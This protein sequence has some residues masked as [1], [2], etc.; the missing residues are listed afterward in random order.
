MLAAVLLGTSGRARLQCSPLKGLIR[1][2]RTLLRHQAWQR[3][4]RLQQRSR[5]S[6]RAATQ[7]PRPT[8]SG[9]QQ[10]ARQRARAGRCLLR[11]RPAQALARRPAR[12]KQAAQRLLPRPPPPPRL[13]L[14]SRALHVARTPASRWTCG[15]E[16]GWGAERHWQKGA[17]P[18]RSLLLQPRARATV[19]LETL[20]WA[21]RGA[22]GRVRSGIQTA[23]RLAKCCPLGVA[24]A[25]G[26]LRD[27]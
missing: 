15:Q 2:H 6:S 10:A 12:A 3:L 1:A 23:G 16:R 7:H 11:R 5:C 25:P 4:Q 19:S 18:L 22:L 8:A 27:S 9:P 21:L 14:A 26:V 17:C 24:G 13:C 20:R